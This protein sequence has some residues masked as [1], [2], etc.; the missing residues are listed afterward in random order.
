VVVLVAYSVINVVIQTFIQPKVVGDTVGL[1][2]TV[3]FLS[4]AFWAWVL[5]P[6]GALL[7]IPLTL[8]AKALRVDVDADSRWLRPLISGGAAPL[9]VEPVVEGETS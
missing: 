2:T 6:L 8:F 3:T 5:G 1:A 9:V 4:L 7:A